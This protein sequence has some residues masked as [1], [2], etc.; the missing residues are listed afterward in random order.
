[1]KYLVSNGCSL[2][3][4]GVKEKGWD[5]L[6][7][8]NL[9]VEKVHKLSESGSSNDGIFRRTYNWLISSDIVKDSMVVIQLTDLSRIEWYYHNQNLKYKTVTFDSSDDEKYYRKEWLANHYSD[10]FQ[11]NHLFRNIIGLQNTFIQNKIPYLFFVG[12]D[13]EYVKEI[14]SSS[15]LSHE[16]FFDKR[17]YNGE[18]GYPT[19]KAHEE[20]SNI[21]FE[22][23]N[24]HGLLSYD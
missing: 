9:G 18:Y 3:A 15:L 12:F 2:T 6:L 7:G 10:E 19:E 1:M 11:Y 5:D 17:F 22:H 24:K 23:I 16:R 20:Y 4:Q 14:E 8:K 13:N 21:L